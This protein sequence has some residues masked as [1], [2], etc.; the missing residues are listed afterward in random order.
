[1]YFDTCTNNQ[2]ILDYDGA[3]RRAVSKTGD[4]KMVG[5]PAP[6]ASKMSRAVDQSKLGSESATTAHTHTHTHTHTERSM[7]CSAPCCSA[8]QSTINAGSSIVLTGECST[9]CALKVVSCVCVCVCL[10]VSQVRASPQGLQAVR[11]LPPW[12]MGVTHARGLPPPH[13]R[14]QLR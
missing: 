12:L 10:V 9:V 14:S 4:M 11:W 7:L 3:G 5:G 1:M 2:P 8:Q 13:S 6:A